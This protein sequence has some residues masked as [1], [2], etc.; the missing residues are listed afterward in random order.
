MYAVSVVV[1]L[2][3][4]EQFVN[5]CIE[6]ITKQTL[7][8]IEIIVV[9]DGSTDSS[10][11]IINKL[12]IN[13]PRI[14]LINQT[15]QGVAAARN[16]GIFSAK[17]EYIAFMDPDDMYPDEYVLEKMYKKAKEYNALICGGSISH[18]WLDGS[19]IK[20]FETPFHKLTFSKEEKIDFEKY[21][22]DY[23]FYRFIYSRKLL[24]D[25][26][27]VFPLYKRFQDPPFMVKA[28]IAAKWFYAIPDVTYQYRVGIQPDPSTW[29]SEKAYDMMRG[30]IDNIIISK[31]NHLADLHKLAV[32]HLFEHRYIIFDRI[33]KN[34]ITML[35]L[36]IKAQVNIDSDL[37]GDCDYSLELFKEMYNRWMRT[38]AQRDWNATLYSDVISS[39]S[40]KAGRV[41]TYIPR[42]IRDTLK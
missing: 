1:P 34:D 7:K 21:Q 29:S 9:N 2:Y 38:I 35:G 41:L 16:K 24:I 4:M 17:G 25:N 37:F 30:M 39:K 6:S 13:D 23:A 19:V 33:E 10:A 18:L 26:N 5:E 8:N 27:I 20:K 36:L 40:F 42:K 28:M 22:F 12:Q 11:S 32:F 15:N 31:Q 14:V 3:N